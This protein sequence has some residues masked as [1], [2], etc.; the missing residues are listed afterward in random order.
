VNPGSW[1]LNRESLAVLAQET[2]KQ[3]HRAQIESKAGAGV[4]RGGGA[5]K[6]VAALTAIN[7]YILA[8][9]PKRFLVRREPALQVPDAELTFCILFI[10]STLA[11]LFFFDAYRRQLFTSVP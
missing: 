1:I 10:T 2:P 4:I 11:R 6:R 5:V 3:A 7:L 9:L 8:N